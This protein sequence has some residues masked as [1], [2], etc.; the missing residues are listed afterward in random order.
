MKNG[1]WWL[2]FLAAAAA[3]ALP[4]KIQSVPGG[5]ALVEL[6]EFGPKPP[7]VFFENRA[8]RVERTKGGEWAALVGVS[9]SAKPGSALAVTHREQGGAVVHTVF[10]VGKRDY[11]EQRIRID[12]DRYVHPSPQELARIT[13]ESA[14]LRAALEGFSNDRVSPLGLSRPVQGRVSGAFGLRRFFNDEPRSPHSGLDLAAARH[15]PVKA[16]QAGRVALVDDFF[17]CGRFV[18]LDHG[19]GFHTLYCHLE[20]TAVKEGQ[21]VKSGAKIGTVGSSGR[22]T[23]PHLHW[24]VS[25][26]GVWVDPA[27]L[28]TSSV[29]SGN[30]TK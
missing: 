14:R 29:S 13:R 11:P 1:G 8:V 22:A 9:L 15:T 10:P 12:Q 19:Q 7:E 25:L 20:K 21:G 27:Y 2:L 23:G 4:A 26:N 16:A 28:L 30:K 3:W 18:L 24:G 6:G 5:I 17:F